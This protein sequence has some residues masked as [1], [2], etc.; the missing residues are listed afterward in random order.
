MSWQGRLLPVER[1]LFDS[2]TVRI[3]AF[4]CPAGHGLFTDSGPI[5]DHLFAFPRTVVEIRHEGGAPFIGTPNIAT[6]YNRGQVYRRRAVAAAPDH[7][8]WF[9]ISDDVLIEVLARSDPSTRDR[10][11]RPF[12]AAWLPTSAK[13]YL[14]QRQL[15]NA[16]FAGSADPLHVEEE[17]LGILASLL[18]PAARPSGPV[19]RA[20]RERVEQAKTVIAE[21]LGDPLSLREIASAVDSS[22]FHL[23]RLFRKQT[24]VTI[25]EFRDQLRL[26]TALDAVAA[27]DDL[28]GVAVDLNYSSHSHFTS[29]FRRAF[30]MPPSVFRDGH[31]VSG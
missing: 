20:G 12:T 4:R 10:P 8:D 6:V 17:A 19:A 13:L 14:R 1:L 15:V 24:G 11:A 27:S 29:R 2:D 30:G 5:G 18:G 25:R 21:R 23:C 3:G 7:C 16:L 31:G 9:A 22:P 26:R 28:L